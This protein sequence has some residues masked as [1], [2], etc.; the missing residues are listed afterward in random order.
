MAF[1]VLLLLT[2]GAE[3]AAGLDM[4]AVCSA[5]VLMRL[6]AAAATSCVVEATWPLASRLLAVWG[7]LCG[8]E[9][10]DRTAAARAISRDSAPRPKQDEVSLTVRGLAQDSVGGICANSATSCSLGVSKSASDV[11][12]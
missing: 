2:T 11:G 10:D 7:L 12:A 1:A 8:L 3:E 6:A 9:V 4:A 5:A